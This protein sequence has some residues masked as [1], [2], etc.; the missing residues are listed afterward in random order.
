ML[1]KELRHKAGDGCCI[2]MAKEPHKTAIPFQGQTDPLS[3]FYPVKDVISIFGQKLPTTDHAYQSNK[4]TQSGQDITSKIILES[5]NGKIAKDE[6]AFMPYNPDW[7]TMKQATM[8]YVL[9]AKAK[10]CPEFQTALLKT[11][12]NILTEAVHK[13]YYWSR[14]HQERHWPGQNVMGK[15]L[16]ELRTKLRNIEKTEKRRKKPKK[17][18]TD[19]ES[20]YEY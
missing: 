10:S 17:N 2:A 15:L 13:E 8:K 6:S 5:K 14:K 18:E 9:E 16:R 12:N 7:P 20:D 3:N 19:S 4:V 11:E 1:C